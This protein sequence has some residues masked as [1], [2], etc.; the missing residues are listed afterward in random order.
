MLQVGRVRR[1]TASILNLA[2]LLV[3]QSIRKAVGCVVAVGVD[4]DGRSRTRRRKSMGR[5]SVVATMK[6]L[7][8]LD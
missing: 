2:S 1:S 4:A 8:L 7:L 5:D 3:S 6:L